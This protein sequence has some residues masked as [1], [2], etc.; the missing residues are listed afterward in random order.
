MSKA[1]VVLSGG[2]DSTTA[3]YWAR[4]RYDEVEAVSINYGQRHAIELGYAQNTCEQL[5][6]RHDVL[7]AQSLGLV[8]TGSALTDSVEVPHGHYEAENML[9]T[10]VPN[11]N[12]IML[13]IVAG[14]AVARG[15]EAIVTG[16]HAGDHAIYPDCRPEFIDALQAMLTVAN[17][18]RIK[19][20]APFVYMSKTRIVSEGAA[21]GVP[22]GNTYSCYEGGLTHCGQ[23][24][25][26][27]ERIESFTEAGVTDPT[28]YLIDDE[29]TTD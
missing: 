25:T 10:V 12:A 16:V 26:C 6:I 28:V 7:A 11:R 13:N 22:F 8:L 20:E 2:L 17:Y 1:I 3:L 29:N 9:S 21:L 27:V 15:A 23:C 19:V 4:T 5:G 18:E 24:G 14:I